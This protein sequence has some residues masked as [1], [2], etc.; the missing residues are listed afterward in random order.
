MCAYAQNARRDGFYTSFLDMVLLANCLDKKLMFVANVDSLEVEDSLQVLSGLLPGDICITDDQASDPSNLWY[1]LLTRYDCQV[2]KKASELNHWIPCWHRSQLGDAA[3]QLGL[4]TYEHSMISKK[5]KI[6]AVMVDCTETLEDEG[7][8]EDEHIQAVLENAMHDME[9][10][11]AEEKCFAALHSLDLIP[12]QV[13]GDGNCGL[14]SILKLQDTGPSFLD[15]PRD[16]TGDEMLMNKMRS[17]RMD[18]WTDQLDSQLATK[19]LQYQDHPR[20]ARWFVVLSV[21]ILSQNTFH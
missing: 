16:L 1:V 11:E 2:A 19:A 17:L 12:E 9:L 6:Q 13:P 4:K 3:F 18:T 14:W 15:E 10:A 20:L 7:E 8:Q 21:P 5:V